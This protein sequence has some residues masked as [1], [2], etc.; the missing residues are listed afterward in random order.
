MAERFASAVRG[1]SRW[2]LSVVALIATAVIILLLGH[3]FGYHPQPVR[4]A[5]E[6]VLYAGLILLMIAS[7]ISVRRE[8]RKTD[9]MIE[10]LLQ[11][12]PPWADLDRRLS[13]IVEAVRRR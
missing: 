10:R 6:W 3:W 11:W 1:Y 7:T 2:R 12:E 5:A 8:I 13:R 9:R 4:M